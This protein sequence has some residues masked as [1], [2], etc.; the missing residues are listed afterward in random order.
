MRKSGSREQQA[1]RSQ[2]RPRGW[3]PNLVL[4]RAPAGAKRPA[5][6]TR[7]PRLLRRATRPRPGPRAALR[8][9]SNRLV[10]ILPGC[11]K[12]RTLYGKAT[13]WSHRVNFPEPLDNQKSR[14]VST[15]PPGLTA[16]ARPQARPETRAANLPRKQSAAVRPISTESS[17]RLELACYLQLRF[18]A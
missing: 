2:H 14:G 3:Q 11:L 6:L 12:S 5:S 4:S 13:A 18:A 8:A 1:S 16:R 17:D 7:R 15:D 9:L 10:G